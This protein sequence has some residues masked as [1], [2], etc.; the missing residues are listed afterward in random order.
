MGSYYSAY[1]GE[2]L[3]RQFDELLDA[4]AKEALRTALVTLRTVYTEN[5]Y[6]PNEDDGILYSMHW[7]MNLEFVNG[8]AVPRGVARDIHDWV[9]NGGEA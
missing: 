7:L 8:K 5:M 6:S 3:I 4:Y 9:F 1:E 2:P